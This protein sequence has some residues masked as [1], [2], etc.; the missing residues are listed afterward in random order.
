MV[1]MVGTEMLVYAWVFPCYAIFGGSNVH[2]S[3]RE[4]LTTVKIRRVL[5]PYSYRCTREVV[6]IGSKQGC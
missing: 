6:A 4:N 5:A 2:P 3:R 1:V